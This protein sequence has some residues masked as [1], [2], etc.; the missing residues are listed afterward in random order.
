[1]PHNNGHVKTASLRRRNRVNALSLL[2]DRRGLSDLLA[3]DM[4]F[5]KVRKPSGKFVTDE[6]F[7]RDREDLC[8]TY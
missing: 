8:N 4:S 5:N 2:D 3:E 6:L 1:M 7:R